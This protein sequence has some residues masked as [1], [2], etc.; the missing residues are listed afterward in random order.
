[1]NE[2]FI[3]KAQKSAMAVEGDDVATLDTKLTK[4]DQAPPAAESVASDGLSDLTGNTRESKAKAYAVKE[5]KKVASQYISSIDNMKDKHNQAMTDLMEKLCIAE[6]QLKLN[7][8]VEVEEER[9]TDKNED[10]VEKE[11]E[12]VEA[13]DKNTKKIQLILVQM[14]TT[15][16]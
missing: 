11:D 12:Q 1:M 15:L 2:V 5:S 16:I 8:N 14:I 13:S 10:K 3:S 9:T 6:L 7:R 4:G